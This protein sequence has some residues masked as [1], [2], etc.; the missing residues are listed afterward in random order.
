MSAFKE[1]EPGYAQPPPRGL[2][3]KAAS[4]YDSLAS[5]DAWRVRQDAEKERQALA[6]SKRESVDERRQRL[7]NACWD[8]SSKRTNA[9]ATPEVD[10]SRELVE[11]LSSKLHSVKS[12]LAQAQ[13][14]PLESLLS[15]PSLDYPHALSDAKARVESEESRIEAEKPKRAGEGESRATVDKSKPREGATPGE[16]PTLAPQSKSPLSLEPSQKLKR[17]L[18]GHVAIGSSL[19][20]RDEP[21]ERGCALCPVCRKRGLWSDRLKRFHKERM[22][23][24]VSE[25]RGK[26]QSSEADATPDDPPVNA[27]TKS[28]SHE[29]GEELAASIAEAIKRRQGSA[30]RLGKAIN[31]IKRCAGNRVPPG[32]AT[33]TDSCRD[34]QASSVRELFDEIEL[35]DEASASTPRVF[36]GKSASGKRRA[37]AT[38]VDDGLATCEDLDEL[39]SLDKQTREKLND[40]V[41]SEVSCAKLDYL[42]ALAQ[43]DHGQEATLATQSYIKETSKEHGVEGVAATPAKDSLLRVDEEAEALPKA[44]KEKRLSRYNK[45]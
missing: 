18:N 25:K 15:D 7:A 33:M 10:A 43:V 3:N 21:S 4:V 28:D 40:E 20:P 37:L 5:Q 26:T 39:K 32:R 31:A 38:H 30:S 23:K 36:N 12:R 8:R 17:A 27:L 6:Q 24:V 45:R 9:Q 35:S 42:G 22:S 14:R 29:L 13:E 2:A 16:G 1:K 41:D 34:T 19:K 11:G 44:A